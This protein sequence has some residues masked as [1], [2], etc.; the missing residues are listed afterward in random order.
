MQAIWNVVWS[1]VRPI[2]D[3]VFGIGYKILFAFGANAYILVLLAI[4]VLIL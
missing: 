2:L 3:A 4:V 1:M